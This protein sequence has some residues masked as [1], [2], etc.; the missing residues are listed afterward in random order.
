VI[1][2][3][4]PEGE[5]AIQESPYWASRYAGEVI[6]GRWPEGEPAIASDAEAAWRYARDVIK[7][8]WPEGN[9]VSCPHRIVCDCPPGMGG[10]PPQTSER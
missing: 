9:I 4:W 3:P 10:V 7:G 6:G 1:G 2:G 8:R 5:K